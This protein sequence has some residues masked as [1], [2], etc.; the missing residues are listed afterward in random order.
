MVNG[1]TVTTNTSMTTNGK[2]ECVPPS[3]CAPLE[4]ITQFVS[5]VMR[6]QFVLANTLC[7]HILKLEPD[8]ET[9][10][11]FRTVL[12]MAIKQEEEEEEEEEEDEEGDEKD[13]TD[14]QDESSDSDN[15]SSDTSSDEN[16]E[17]DDDDDDEDDDEEDDDDTDTDGMSSSE[18]EDEDLTIDEVN[19]LNLLMGGLTVVKKG[20]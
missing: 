2:N 6:K 12:D 7:Q 8:N 9:C 5:A 14:S 11:E 16:T 3:Q 10:K 4:L 13:G 17:E 15:E 18:D 19:R 20:V 1:L